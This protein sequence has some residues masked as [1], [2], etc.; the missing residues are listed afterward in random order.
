[1]NRIRIG[2]VGLVVASLTGLSAGGASAAVS[3]RGT[4]SSSIT[5]LSVDLGNVQHLKV[6][7]DQ[8]QGTLDA[9]R[10]GLSGPQAFASL[11]AVDASGLLN[12][13]LPNPAMKATAPGTSNASL[14]PLAVNFPGS[15]TAV[16]GTSLPL[17]AGLIASGTINPAKIEAHQTDASV[18]SVVG[19][20][21]PDLSILQGLSE[22]K[23]VNIAGLTAS[24]S[25]SA[26]KGD[27]GIVGI[28]SVDVLSLKGLLGGLGLNVADLPLGSLTGI[29]DQLGLSVPGVG[30]LGNLNGASITEL[31]NNVTGLLN[32]KNGL[33]GAADCSALTSLVN[34]N[35]GGLPD[36]A[37]ILGSGGPLSGVLGLLGLS[38]TGGLTGLLGTC[39]TVS[40]LTQPILDI[41]NPT[42][43]SLLPDATSAV[44]GLLNVLN[45]AP[46]ISLQGVN[47]S[48]VANAADTLA[49]SSATTT[50]NFGHILVGGKDLGVIDVNAAIDQVNA[51][52]GSVLG[53]VNGITSTLGLG[54]LIDI[55]LLERTAS[56]KV[57][58]AYNV[59]SAGLDL[60][61][62]SI[63]PPAN[64]GGLLQSATANP[65]S[66]VLGTLGAA[67]P[68]DTGLATNA[69][70]QAFGL[71]SLLT[72]PTTIKV[73]SIGADADFT[74]AVEGS[75]VSQTPASGQTGPAGTLPRTGGTDGAWYAA[76]AAISLAG[77]FGITRSLRKSPATPSHSDEL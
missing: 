31:L 76:L 71:T 33:A 21:V 11:S 22:I 27:T 50:A 62:V 29:L 65:L 18:D 36:L 70:A 37:G 68:A 52:K 40:A 59:A 66:G 26:S 49:N 38:S 20:S 2:L 53:L 8:G 46:L 57:D 34:N 41:I 6:L 77:A 75:N 30:S 72:Q 64:L 51:L 24:A 16:A 56:T 63:N 48:A 69:V 74:T 17:G 73:G 61:R 15:A 12:L 55:G 32:V 67:V 13:S 10:L 25:A 54:N 47:I 44:D 9:A 7:T 5:L 35:L 60:L 42:L 45:G 3:G 19:T 39:S 28:D 1:V 23:G 58:G 4:A 14:A 43:N